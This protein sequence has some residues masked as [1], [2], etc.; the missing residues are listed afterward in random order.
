[1]ARNNSNQKRDNVASTEPPEARIEQPAKPR[2]LNVTFNDVD[3]QW[4]QTNLP[5]QL[6]I[7]DEMYTAW[8]DQPCRIAVAYDAKSQRWNATLTPL[9]VGSPRHGLILSCR[10][11][12][13]IVALF[14][15]AYADGYKDGAWD[16]ASNSTEGLFG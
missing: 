9:V 4:L 8:Q 6:T 12:Y 10:A 16:A 11:K 1:M 14:C 13:P 2:W 3:Q 15:L 7:I 5:N